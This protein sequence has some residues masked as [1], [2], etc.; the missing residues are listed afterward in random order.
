MLVYARMKVVKIQKKSSKPISRILFPVWLNIPVFHHLSG[1]ST[2]R[3]QASSPQAPVYVIF[4]PVRRTAGNVTITAG[5]L[6]PCLLT[7]ARPGL[8]PV[9]RFFSSPLLCPHGHL[10]FQKYVALCCP[11]FPPLSSIQVCMKRA[12]ERSTAFYLR[13]N[14]PWLH[15]I[16]IHGMRHPGI[17][18]QGISLVIPF[19]SAFS[20]FPVPPHV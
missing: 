15:Q 10:L 14:E 5:R 20:G 9:R 2:P 8:G 18:I 4:Q 12:M 1:R 6:L 17:K 11:D 13:L 7:L 16:H 19:L 3:Y